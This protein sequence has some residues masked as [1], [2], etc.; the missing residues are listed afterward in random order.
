[1]LASS[2]ELALVL[3]CSRGMACSGRFFL[4]QLISPIHFGLTITD[5]ES[6]TDRYSPQRDRTLDSATVHRS[7]QD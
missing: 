4:S 2:S 6:Y 5:L 1:M 7:F 3:A